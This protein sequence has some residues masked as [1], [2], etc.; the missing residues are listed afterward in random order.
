[1]VS[2]EFSRFRNIRET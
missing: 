1:M 2:L